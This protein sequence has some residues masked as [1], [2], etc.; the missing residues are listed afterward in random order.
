MRYDWLF[1]FGEG[2]QVPTLF[3]L[4]L[5][6]LRGPMHPEMAQPWRRRKT[7]PYVPDTWSFYMPKTALGR[8]LS[9][10]TSPGVFLEVFSQSQLV[11]LE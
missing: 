5:L 11:Q 7:P 6:A 3:F 8:T 1:L 2:L 10:Q 4:F 9:F